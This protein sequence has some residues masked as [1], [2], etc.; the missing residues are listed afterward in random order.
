MSGCCINGLSV[1]QIITTVQR[2]ARADDRR[3]TVVLPS[4]GLS[5]IGIYKPYATWGWYT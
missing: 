3:V 1:R 5:S 2:V 4:H